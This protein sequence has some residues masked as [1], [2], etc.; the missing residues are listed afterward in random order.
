MAGAGRAVTITLTNPD[1]GSPQAELL[2][3]AVP[4]VQHWLAEWIASL[5]QSGPDPVSL[6]VTIDTGR[7]IHSADA[8]QLALLTAALLAAED[9]PAAHAEPL[10]AESG[11]RPDFEPFGVSEMAIFADLDADEDHLA[12]LE[13]TIADVLDGIATVH[14]TTMIGPTGQFILGR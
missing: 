11:S 7:P 4:V 9:L 5:L 10:S 2:R 6:E 12:Q 3:A 14:Q 8:A 1:D 13:A